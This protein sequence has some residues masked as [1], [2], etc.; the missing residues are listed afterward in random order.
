MFNKPSIIICSLTMINQRVYATQKSVAPEQPILDYQVLARNYYHYVT[1]Q[2]SNPTRTEDEF[3]YE[4]YNEYKNGFRDYLIEFADENN[5]ELDM[6]SDTPVT[7][8]SSGSEPYIISDSKT[9][10]DQEITSI[11]FS[12][13]PIYKAFDYS[14]IQNGDIFVETKTKYAWI[15]HCG[16]ISNTNKKSTN[17]GTYVQTIEAVPDSVSFGYLDDWRIINYGIQIYRPKTNSN[18]SIS[19]NAISYMSKQIGKPYSLHF[20]I[21]IKDDSG[22]YCSELV[23]AAYYKS[24][25]DVSERGS[26]LDKINVEN[27]GYS[28]VIYPADIAKSSNVSLQEINDYFLEL[29]INGK[30]STLWGIR[31]K[32]KTDN[33][34]GIFYNE[35]M[36]FSDDAKLW[37]NLNDIRTLAAMPKETRTIGIYENW[38]ATTIALSY[39][40]YYMGKQVRLISYADGLNSTTSEMNMYHNI[41]F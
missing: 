21:D 25:L 16:I 3:I 17:Y 12:Q 36:C 2:V 34:I 15:G 30:S 26:G 6:T 10:F 28:S 1:D 9:A 22:W 24:V 40:T 7:R 38:S 31:A 33:V 20:S 27:G 18:I 8:E 5:V 37:T 23:Y 11:D 39:T 4:F 29:S 41:L 14:D 13:Q 35:K 19:N 32:N